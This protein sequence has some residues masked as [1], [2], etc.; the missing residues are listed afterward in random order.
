MN[1]D[2]LA[3][4]YRWVEYAGMGRALARRRSEFLPDMA[5]ARRVLILGEGDGR[6]LA[7]LL[8]VNGQA[9]IDVVDN[10]VRM[11]ALA[12]K[13]AEDR[14]GVE[15]VGRRVRF[16]PADASTWAPP[17]NVGYDLIATHFFLDCFSDEALGPMVSRF[18]VWAADP[19]RWVVSEF[20]QPASGFPAWRARVWIGTLYRLFGWTTGL[21]VRRLPD[22]GSALER[23]GF[24]RTKAVIKEMGLLTSE[25]WER[26]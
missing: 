6:F 21:R 8:G 17:G 11:L 15:T 12:R 7:K 22:H 1:C 4:W 20:R 13:R 16:H 19:C 10:S 2:P 18:A 26:P 25:L 3:R 24:R 5:T 9:E 23:S 14:A